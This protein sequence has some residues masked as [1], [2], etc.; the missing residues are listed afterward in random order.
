M[1]CHA[2]WAVD[3]LVFVPNVNNADA[4]DVLFSKS[5]NAGAALYGFKVIVQHADRD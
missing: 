1:Y 2:Y 5:L 3:I 4:A